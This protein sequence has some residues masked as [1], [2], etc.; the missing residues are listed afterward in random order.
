LGLFCLKKALKIQYWGDGNFAE[1]LGFGGRTWVSLW[2]RGIGKVEREKEK[3]KAPQ[4]MVFYKKGTTISL[5]NAPNCYWTG[6]VRN[7]KWLEN[8]LY[9]RFRSEMG[10]NGVL[11]K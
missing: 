7:R 10:L 3:V 6:S 4:R 8:A 5:A 9:L 2:K 11:R 1:L